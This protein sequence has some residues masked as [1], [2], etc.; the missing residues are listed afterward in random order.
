MNWSFLDRVYLGERVENYIWF[1][2]IIVGT[3]LLKRVLANVLSRISNMFT[4]RFNDTRRK[5]HVMRTMLRQPI[6]KLIQVI[7]YYVAVD[8]ISGLMDRV[9]LHKAKAGGMTL[10]L[11]D[12]VDHIFLFLFIIFLTQ[13]ISRVI[14]MAYYLKLD[15]ADDEHNRNQKQ[16]LPLMKEM[17]KLVLWVL[18]TFWILGSVFHVNIPA[19]ITGLGIGG[20]AIALAGKE[21]VENLFAAFTIL[22]DKPF[23][24]GETI[25]L[26][27][28]EGT[29]ER[30]GFRST[31]LR[32]ADGA[33]YIIPNQKLVGE[34]LVNLSQRNTR[35]AKLTVN[36]KYGISHDKLQ[37][38]VEELRQ[39][40]QQTSNVI[41]PVEVS[42]EGFGEKVFQILIGY[43]MP[44]C[45][46]AAAYWR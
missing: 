19:L 34:N 28:F 11:G 37:K 41:S 39:M 16:L 42:I 10:R 24:T 5:K 9:V 44:R 38:M 12:V 40:V 36:I 30:I 1:A 3:L 17:G 15:K 27:D 4:Q 21:T 32:H 26:G 33:A 29:V 6:E 43:H 46:R 22:S 25:K 35:G 8:Q 2:A 45:P 18:A 31:R 23:Q 13:V 7:L 14:D 20:I